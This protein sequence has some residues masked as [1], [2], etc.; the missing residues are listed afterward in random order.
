MIVEVVCYSLESALAAQDA[1]ANRIELCGGFPEGGTTPS[2]A[3]IELVQR[4]LQI[5]V[6]V[7]IRPRGGDF[8]YSDTEFE[9]M[10]RDVEI[11]KNLQVAGVVFGLLNPDGSL[12][13]SH[14]VDLIKHASPLNATLHRAFDRT[15]DP[16]MSLE[17]AVFCGFSRILTSG[18]EKTA[19]DGSELLKK[20]IEKAANRIVI[21]PG[22]GITDENIL[23][24]HNELHACEYHLSGKKLVPTKM[25][26][27]NVKINF[28]LNAD[29]P[30]EYTVH[31][32]VERIRRV[33]ELLN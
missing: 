9:V 30:S 27:N 12:D 13:I 14:C 20:L 6:H 24:L 26:Y 31:T 18:L 15:P 16:F 17:D 8:L 3:L 19:I 2:F 32:D 5:P 28:N 1:G 33:V 23:S 4:K 10:M 7:M 25:L 22:C 11:C 21:M 29:E